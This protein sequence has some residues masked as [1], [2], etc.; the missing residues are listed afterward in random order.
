MKEQ[1]HT[2]EIGLRIGLDPKATSS[3][4]AMV[5]KLKSENQYIKLS[6]SKFISFIVS[7][8]FE[9]QFE[10]DITVL[11]HYFFNSK[12]FLAEELPKAKTPEEVKE[13]LQK[14]MQGLD[15]LDL[16]VSKLRKKKKVV[17]SEQSES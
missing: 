4:R 11:D 7:R 10:K 9:G 8:Y 13:V 15:K 6:P 14:V 3:Y 12:E 2:V 16:D 17:P 1:E 5:Q